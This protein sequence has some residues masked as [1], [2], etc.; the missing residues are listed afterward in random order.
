LAEAEL[1]RYSLEKIKNVNGRIRTYGLVT[2]GVGVVAL[3]VMAVNSYF[4]GDY[5]TASLM[6]VLELPFTT[7]TYLFERATR[8]KK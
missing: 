5:G 1:G 7:A 2:H 4:H 3:A 6:T 8:P